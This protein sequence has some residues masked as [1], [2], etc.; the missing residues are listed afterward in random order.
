MCGTEIAL[1]RMSK[2]NGGRGGLIVNTASGA[3]LT[4]GFWDRCSY[5]YP[6]TKFGV[7]ALTRALGVSRIRFVFCSDLFY[8]LLFQQKSVFD[9]TGVKFQCICPGFAD[10]AIIKPIV[11]ET[12]DFMDKIGVM[13]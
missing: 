1:E 5:T 2:E 6:V 10:T 8:Y 12:R 11:G 9:Q 13:T 7:V 4:H 3:G